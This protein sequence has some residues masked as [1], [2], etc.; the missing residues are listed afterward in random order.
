[1][2]QLG[3]VEMITAG[4][5]LLF[6]AGSFWYFNNKIEESMTKLDVLSRNFTTNIGKVS[7]HDD[8]IK[9]LRSNSSDITQTIKDLKE[10]FASLSTEIEQEFRNRDETISKLDK[11][12]QLIQNKLG[13]VLD[14]MGMD[15]HSLYQSD[16]ITPTK[17][18]K[19][20]NK[21]TAVEQKP[22]EEV[23]ELKVDENSAE[24]LLSQM[25]GIINVGQR[26]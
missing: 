13:T 14:S 24:Y 4:G 26:Y 20:L 1:M 3:K 11:K 25:E 15:S 9:I 22:V 17:K 18:S 19:K 7:Q 10:S 8:E 16:R 6:S 21:K 12:M 23:P 5:A 2:E